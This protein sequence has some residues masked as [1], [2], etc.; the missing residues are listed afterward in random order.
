MQSGS[1]PFQ[2][3][4]LYKKGVA[5]GKGIAITLVRTM[6]T[7]LILSVVVPIVL[8]MDPAIL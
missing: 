4:V 3:Y 7:V 8:A 1:G 6:L 5:I 2:V